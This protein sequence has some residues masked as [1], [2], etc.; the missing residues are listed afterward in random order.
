MGPSSSNNERL[1]AARAAVERG[2]ET[3][4]GAQL[5]LGTGGLIAGADKHK[6][7]WDKQFGKWA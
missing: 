3:I 1:N 5:P 2:G 6:K 7:S 4:P